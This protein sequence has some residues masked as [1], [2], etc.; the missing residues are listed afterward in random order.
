[1]TTKELQDT[2]LY[3]RDNV[4]DTGFR[5]RQKEIFDFAE[6]YKSFLDKSKTERRSVLSAIQIAENAG[7][8]PLEHQT[9]LKPGDK[10]YTVNR[11]KGIFLAVIGKESLNSGIRLVAAH[12]DAPRLDLKPNPVYED[13]SLALL[14]THYYGGIK[15]YQWPTIPLALY[16]VVYLADGTKVDISIGDH[17]E[18]PVFYITDLL[19]HL[20]AEQ[21][22]KKLAQGIAGESLNLLAGSIPYEDKEAKERVKLNLLKILYDSYGICE[23]DF[24]SAELEAVPAFPARDVGLDRSMIGAYGHDD[25]VCSYTALR[26]VCTCEAPEKTAVCI[27]VDKEEIGS[28]GNTGMQ[29][30]FFEHMLGELCDKTA[31]SLRLCM[32]NST[33]LSAD[34]GAANDPTYPSVQEKN[35]A[36][37]LNGGIMIAKYTGARGKSGSSDASAELVGEIRRLFEK[38]GIVWQIAELGKVDEGGGGTVAQFVANLDIDTIDCGVPLLSMHAPYEIAAKADVYMAYLAYKAFL[39]E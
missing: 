23:K 18:D 13:M 28:M 22:G 26:A 37:V 31:S 16:G 3:Q 29:S 4:Y 6:E 36:A 5:D 8:V 17:P 30:R 14:K 25:R 35:N 1:M 38:N 15:K 2:L 39:S 20:A 7:F 33:C 10:V 21:M 12:I 11:G 32:R 24:I 9:A 34:V 19:P 27:L